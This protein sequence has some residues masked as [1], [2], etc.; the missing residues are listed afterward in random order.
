MKFSNFDFHSKIQNRKFLKFSKK[1]KKSEL[2][3]EKLKNQKLNSSITS[4]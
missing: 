4:R 1:L 2:G 3:N